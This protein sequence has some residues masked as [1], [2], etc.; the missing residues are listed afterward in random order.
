MYNNRFTLFTNNVNP[1][2]LATGIQFPNGPTI[3]G[4]VSGGSATGY[5]YQASATQPV[6]PRVEVTVQATNIP[7]APGATQEHQVSGGITY[8]F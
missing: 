4:N 7:S 6:A 1:Q 2:A 5:S 8:K 3:Q